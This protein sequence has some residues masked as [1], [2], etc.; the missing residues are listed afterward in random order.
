MQDLTACCTALKIIAYLHVLTEKNKKILSCQKREVSKLCIKYI[1]DY[2][3]Q[4]KVQ[5]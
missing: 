4:E 2:D 5:K 3:K 1:E